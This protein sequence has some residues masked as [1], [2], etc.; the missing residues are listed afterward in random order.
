MGTL[1][2]KDIEAMTVQELRTTL[3]QV[4]DVFFSLAAFFCYC[5]CG[6]ANSCSLFEHVERL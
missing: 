6:H 4:Y 2:E 5:F 1:Q 3:R